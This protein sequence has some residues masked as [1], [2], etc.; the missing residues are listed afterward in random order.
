MGNSSVLDDVTSK[1]KNEHW[2]MAAFA[3]VTSGFGLF[4]YVKERMEVH[5]KLDE[6]RKE[7]EID[8]LLMRAFFDNDIEDGT[9]LKK[10]IE[11]TVEAASKQGELYYGITTNDILAR[12]AV[13]PEPQRQVLKT[14][15]KSENWREFRDQ[16]GAEKDQGQTETYL[17]SEKFQQDK[18][19]Q[20]DHL[21]HHRIGN[22][23]WT[24]SENE[25]QEFIQ[26]QLNTTG[27]GE[28]HNI[29]VQDV[30]NHYK[31]SGKDLKAEPLEV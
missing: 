2:A 5:N 8:F 12:Y 22:D 14:G 11:K 15:S 21:V 26:Y 20:L 17:N 30:L 24:L 6:D 10:A 19:K 3:Q 31:Q 7:T 27:V 13:M 16:F 1:D 23:A 28:S 4:D 18:I 25:R 29:T 9:Q